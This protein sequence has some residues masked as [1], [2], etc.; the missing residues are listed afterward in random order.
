MFFQILAYTPHNRQDHL[1]SQHISTK[2]TVYL[3]TV[4]GL[5]G[6]FL[7]RPKFVHCQDCLH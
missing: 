4:I 2:T 7:N 1:T 3:S 5:R 6:Y